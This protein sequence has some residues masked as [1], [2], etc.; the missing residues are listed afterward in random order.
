MRMTIE[1][2]RKDLE[3][4]IREFGGEKVVEILN[5]NIKIMEIQLQIKKLENKEKEKRQ[6]EEMRRK[7]EEENSR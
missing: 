2:Y 1:L 4:L 7:E 6:K 5:N 3:E